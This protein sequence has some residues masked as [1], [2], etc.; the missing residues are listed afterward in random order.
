[1]FDRKTSQKHPSAGAPSEKAQMAAYAEQFNICADSNRHRYRR[2]RGL[3]SNGYFDSCSSMERWY[4][5]M[6][7]PLGDAIPPVYMTKSV[8]AFGARIGDPHNHYLMGVFLGPSISCHV[9]EANLKTPMELKDIF[10]AIKHRDD[11]IE[12]GIVP[13]RPVQETQ[14][15]PAAFFATPLTLGTIPSNVFRAIMGFD[16]PQMEH[17]LDFSG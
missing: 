17:S 6:V 7:L 10:A 8:S 11:K 9:P 1:M 3:V 5:K 15:G 16:R 14:S 13:V 12:G 2:G 4:G